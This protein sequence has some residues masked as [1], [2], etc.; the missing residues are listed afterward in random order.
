LKK[1]AKN[2]TG[3]FRFITLAH[4]LVQPRPAHKLLLRYRQLQPLAASASE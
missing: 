1:L 4:L 2:S 3:A